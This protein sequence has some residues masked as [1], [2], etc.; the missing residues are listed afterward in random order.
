MRILIG[1]LALAI[2]GGATYLL[3]PEREQADPHGLGLEEQANA[4]TGE[5]V[6]IAH[7]FKDGETWT[8]SLFMEVQMTVPQRAGSNS[9]I[10]ITQTYHAKAKP[11][12]TTTLAYKRVESSQG[13]A[14]PPTGITTGSFRHAKGGRPLH[15]TLTL[16]GA[17]LQLAGTVY[18]N[19]MLA[20]LAG[21][22][23]WIPDRPIRKGESWPVGDV[24]E[25]RMVSVL[26]AQHD[27][28]G[29]GLPAPTFRGSIWVRDIER[30][31]DGGGKIH[32]SIRAL[33]E[34][35]GRVRDAAGRPGSIDMGYR[36]EGVATVDIRTGLPL[37]IEAK[38]TQRM[39]S[40]SAGQAK[41]IQQAMTIVVRSE[42]RRDPPPGGKK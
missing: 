9:T 40:R 6:Q 19:M 28:A 14:E 21:S 37:R 11:H 7:A 39:D 4:P 17:N 41:P 35:R 13:D 3:L 34:V 26:L 18:G 27:R 33:V 1:I 30:D 32:L 10:E 36:V 29:G 20:G 24:L 8:S 31:A 42:A 38:G 2:A 22:G 25:P 5:A 23:P 16:K 15:R 12:T